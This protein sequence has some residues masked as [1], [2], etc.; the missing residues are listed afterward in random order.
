MDKMINSQVS[1]RDEL[2]PKLIL[3]SSSSDSSL[4]GP[5]GSSSL[6]PLGQQISA[7]YSTLHEAGLALATLGSSL[8]RELTTVRNLGSTVQNDRNDLGVLWEI[9]GAFRDG[10]GAGDSRRDWMRE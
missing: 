4:S 8:E 10:R 9:G 6:A 5:G 7:L 1:I 2:Q 3:S